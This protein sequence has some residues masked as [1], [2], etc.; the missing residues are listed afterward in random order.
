MTT[1][2]DFPSYTA[3]GTQF[4]GTGVHYLE[5]GGGPSLLLMHGA[6]PG[7]SAP[8]NFR[9]ILEPLAE[10]YHV[11]AMDLIGF[12]RSGRK[13]DAPYFD[14]EYWVGQA[15]HMLDRIP[16]GPVGIVGH[17]ISAALALR[18]AAANERVT[19]VLTTGAVG[20]AFALTDGL[21][22]LWT[23]PENR[24]QLREAMQAAVHDTASLTDDFLD[25]RLEMLD[26]D[27]YPDYFRALFGGDRQAKIDSWVLSAATLSRIRCPVVLMHGRNDASTPH[28][29]T[30]AV[31]AESL[32]HAD[33]IQ[34]A[35]C[36][37]SPALEHADKFLATANILFGCLGRQSG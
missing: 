31:L 37:H 1:R 2:T 8:G 15:Q 33:V 13:P 4:R 35:A 32:P 34:L 23:F 3:R 10:R 6:G 28:E 20:T 24:D 14:F 12:G 30:T 18:L 11:H 26:Q 5:G 16:E 9:L 22:K 29:L 17:S 7:T 36:G 25:N 21:N 19:A 27:G